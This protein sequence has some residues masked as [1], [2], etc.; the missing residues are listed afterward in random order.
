MTF[1]IVA[2]CEKTGELGIAAVTAVPAVGK[3]LTWAYPGAGAVATQAFINPY[4]GY[5]ALLLLREG[6]SAE[7]AMRRVLDIEPEPELRQLGIVDGA[8][9]VAAWTGPETGGWSGHVTGDGYSVQGNLLVGPETLEAMRKSFLEDAGCSLA[10][11]LLCAIE[12]GEATGGDKRGVTSATVYVMA[13]EV[14]P[15]W[16]LR[17]D[18]HRTPLKELRRLYGV[19][20]REV[21]PEI[22]CLPK[23]DEWRVERRPG[24]LGLA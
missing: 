7:E 15:L 5:D 12:A 19:F 21:V 24:S 8:G 23:R 17:V 13:K 4:L 9:R 14:Y 11:R 20:E 2:R 3:L 10:K 1:S 22:L 18:D 6:A 16:D